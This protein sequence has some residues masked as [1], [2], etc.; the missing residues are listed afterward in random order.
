M[1][2]RMIDIEIDGRTK[3]V[4]PQNIAYIISKNTEVRFRGYFMTSLVFVLTILPSII[5][6]PNLF[7]IGLSSIVGLTLSYI[8]YRKMKS[9]NVKS[10]GT[11]NE[12]YNLSKQDVN[13]LRSAFDEIG[14]E[15]LRIAGMQDTIFNKIDYSYYITPQNVVSVDRIDRSIPS[16]M[17]IAFLLLSVSIISVVSFNYTGMERASGVTVGISLLAITTIFAISNRPDFIEIE[18]TN[19]ETKQVLLSR[20]KARDVVQYFKGQKDL[21]DISENMTPPELDKGS[22]PELE[23][24]DIKSL[25]S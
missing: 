22:K 16:F 25:E 2:D 6:I 14:S 11:V 15:R 20:D 12:S 24:N 19:G 21:S 1:P 13:E 23:E 18:F 3:Q 10:V 9:R 7:T 4:N 8:V 5:I 17:I